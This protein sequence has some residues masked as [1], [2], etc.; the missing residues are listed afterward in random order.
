M[1][2]YS[3]KAK[4]IIEGFYREQFKFHDGSILTYI[5][6]TDEFLLYRSL[7]STMVQYSHY[8]TITTFSYYSCLNSTMVQYSLVITSLSSSMHA[9]FKF[10][11]GSILT[12]EWRW[13]PILVKI[14]MFKFHDGSILTQK[15]RYQR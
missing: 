5:T 15:E 14:Q 1:V 12:K 4:R 7:N 13:A 6:I 11:D 3:Q 9:V 8:Y 2:Q 10:H